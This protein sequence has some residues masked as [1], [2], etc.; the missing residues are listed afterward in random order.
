MKEDER[1]HPQMITYLHED[2]HHPLQL[3]CFNGLEHEHRVFALYR[4]ST[5][6]KQFTPRTGIRELVCDVSK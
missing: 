2:L 5:A 3:A 4:D 6:R 1:S